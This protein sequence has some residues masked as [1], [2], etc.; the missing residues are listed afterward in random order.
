[1]SKGI[2]SA[3]WSPSCPHECWCHDSYL[4]SIV[5]GWHPLNQTQQD[6][7][8]LSTSND[9]I[10]F[11]AAICVQQHDTEIK[12]LLDRLPSQ[13]EV[14]YNLITTYQISCAI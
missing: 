11:R 7:A 10:L 12:T 6:A 5:D 9:D 14:R 1:M 4:S 2:Q 13:A 8:S 3:P